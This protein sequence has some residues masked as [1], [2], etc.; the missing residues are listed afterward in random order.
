[1]RTAVVGHVEWVSFMEVDHVPAPGEIV[2]AGAWWEEAGG[3]GA[4]AAVQLGRLARD[5][6]FF[7]ALGDDAVGHRSYERLEELGVRMRV[8]WRS[9]PARRALTFVDR[10]GERTITVL[11]D[12]HS[13]VATDDLPWDELEAIDAVYFTAGDAGVLRLAREAG[14]VVATT[15]VLSVLTEAGV[16]LDAVVGSAVDPSEA[17]PPGGIEPPPGLVVRTDGARGGTYEIAGGRVGSYASE[18][19]PGPIVDRYGAGDCFAAG[20]TYGLGRGLATE[21]ALK[22]ASLCGAAVITGRGPYEAQLTNAAL[23]ERLSG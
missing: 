13:P 19:P 17:Y 3:G 22:V 18:S 6:T 4:G 14:V 10:A 11:G 2:H 15:R 5:V 9:E 23:E 1:M 21:E 16:Q 7:T 20:L 8:A 12:R